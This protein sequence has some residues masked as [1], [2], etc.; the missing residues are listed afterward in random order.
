MAITKVTLVEGMILLAVM[1]MAIDMA[2]AEG[3][4]MAAVVAAEGRGGREQT[5]SRC[6]VACWRL[7][8][9]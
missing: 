4:P 9:C 8:Q 3:V 1:V 7:T 2:L 5:R 6:V